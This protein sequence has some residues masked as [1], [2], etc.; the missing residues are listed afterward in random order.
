MVAYGDQD[1]DISTREDEEKD[2][3]DESF[4]SGNGALMGPDRLSLRTASKSGQIG[5]GGGTN[6]D[7]SAP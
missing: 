7:P 6:D 4:D 3:L 2:S 1:G 5:G